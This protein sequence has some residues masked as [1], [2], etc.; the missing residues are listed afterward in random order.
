MFAMPRNQPLVSGTGVTAGCRGVKDAHELEL[1]QL[2]STVTLKAYEA[3]YKAL[4]DGMTMSAKK[5]PLANIGGWLACDDDELAERC[6]TMEIL[7]EGFPTYGGLA[8]RDLE[9]MAIGLREVV[10]D[11][12]LRYRIRSTAY[13]GEALVESGIDGGLARRIP[14]TIVLSNLSSDSLLAAVRALEPERRRHVF[15]LMHVV[16][17]YGLSAFGQPADHATAELHGLGI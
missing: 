4:A 10:Q 17:R 16:D 7:T 3:A 1:M 5:D 14:R 6:R 9:A 15:E 12:Y 2:A 13:L 11:D 8:G